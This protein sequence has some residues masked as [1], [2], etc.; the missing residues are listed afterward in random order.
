MAVC[1]WGG[2]LN[3]KLQLLPSQSCTLSSVL[4]FG[5]GLRQLQADVHDPAA[6]VTSLTQ[7]RQLNVGNF[8]RTDSLES[9][10]SQVSSKGCAGARCKHKSSTLS[11]A[12]QAW[13]NQLQLC[14]S[15]PW[16]REVRHA[17]PSHHRER[18]LPDPRI[19]VPEMC[20]LHLM[21]TFL[22]GPL[23]P[24]KAESCTWAARAKFLT[25]PEGRTQPHV[26]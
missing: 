18:E 17:I 2:A 3:H 21:L 4:G 16:Q 19:S 9:H 22:G 5:G 25:T 14:S 11:M 12:E 1:G 8:R 15:L 7:P 23:S 20:F 24:P 10:P 13:L 6:R 26:A